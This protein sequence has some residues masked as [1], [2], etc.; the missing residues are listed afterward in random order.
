M[1]HAMQSM[2]S[3]DS[4]AGLCPGPSLTHST[5][6]CAGVPFHLK[7]R[8]DA[9]WEESIDFE[10]PARADGLGFTWIMD[11]DAGKWYVSLAHSQL[12]RPHISYLN[13]HRPR[14]YAVCVAS[15]TSVCLQVI[16]HELIERDRPDLGGAR[17]RQHQSAA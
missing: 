15:H 8:V 17:W 7:D 3:H 12:T 14:T 11:I 1:L 10:L 4:D 9:A 2:P 16:M 6:L 5:H 13:P